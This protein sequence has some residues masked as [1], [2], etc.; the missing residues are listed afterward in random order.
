MPFSLKMQP[1]L[2]DRFYCHL[3]RA[4]IPRQQALDGTMV[5]LKRYVTL[6]G[7]RGAQRAVRDGK[8]LDFQNYQRYREVVSTPEMQAADGVGRGDRFFTGDTWTGVTYHCPTGWGAFQEFG[9]PPELARMFCQHID[10]FNVEGF[11][12]D[13][14]Y[15]VELGTC[16]VCIHRVA[17]SGIGPDTDL[18]RAPDAPPY[19][20]VIASQFFTMAEVI[21]AIF[22]PV[23]GETVTKV[24]E[25]FIRQYGED[26][27][28]QISQYETANFNIYYP[29][30]LEG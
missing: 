30:C 8:P 14:D 24:K 19:P 13:I 6:R 23:G 27:W 18:S 1:Y 17:C 26:V 2:A 12:S 3:L 11:N 20:F 10:R 28:P 29:K 22:G 21:T 25:D 15:Q 4:G 9:S 5:A 16:P 7:N